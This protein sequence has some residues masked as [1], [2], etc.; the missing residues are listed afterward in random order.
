MFAMIVSFGFV[1]KKRETTLKGYRSGNNYCKK[2]ASCG[3][4]KKGIVGPKVL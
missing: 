3:K 4:K 2:I 1:N